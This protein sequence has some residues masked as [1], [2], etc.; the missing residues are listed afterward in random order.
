MTF[1]R[2]CTKVAKH[3][4]HWKK[5]PLDGSP[6]EILW[7]EDFNDGVAQGFGNEVGS[8]K[9]VD[10]RYTATTGRLRYSTAGDLSWKDYSLDGD[11]HQCKGCS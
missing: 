8:R 1:K 4:D 10:G 3:K 7:H 2:L 6:S 9:V 5:T 11:F